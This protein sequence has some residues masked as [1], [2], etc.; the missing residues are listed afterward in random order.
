MTSSSFGWAKIAILS[1]V[2]YRTTR[3][4]RLKLVLMYHTRGVKNAKTMRKTA[5]IGLVLITAAVT[6]AAFEILTAKY[7]HRKL[8]K[9]LKSINDNS[10]F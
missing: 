4:A 5:I 8:A 1:N 9:W 6:S 2:E 7:V 3:I 10:Y